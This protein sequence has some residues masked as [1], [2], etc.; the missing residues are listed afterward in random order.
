MYTYKGDNFLG[1]HMVLVIG[2]SS[3]IGLG[4]VNHFLKMGKKTWLV[5]KDKEKLSKL[6]DGLKKDYGSLVQTSCVDLL[7]PN[8]V[9][10][11]IQEVEQE[12]DHIEYLVNNAG[13]FKY[14]PFL[15]HTYKDYDDQM[16]LNRAL[17]FMTQAVIKNMLKSGK[18]SIVN[19]GST[20]AQQP[21][22]TA[23]TAAY[24]M[25]KAGLHVLTKNLALEFASSNIRVNTVAPSV[26]VTPAFD[27]LCTPQQLQERFG[28]V[29]PMGRVGEVS[30]MVEAIE[31]FLSDRSSWVTGQCLFVDGGLLAGKN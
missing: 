29:H 30:D 28:P 31:F 25:Q 6:E 2:G 3:G 13:F 10:H 7:Q 15:D 23:P 20:L 5:S 4:V 11:F 16:A 9:N 21:V 17:F 19:V 8:Q 24:S 14:I 12:K 22:R 27:S 18:G 26:T 1:K